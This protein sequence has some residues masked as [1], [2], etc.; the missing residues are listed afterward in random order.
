[1]HKTAQ[2]QRIFVAMSGG[3]DSSTAAALLV[4]EGHDV[5]GVFMKGWHPSFVDCTYKEDR[6][7]A[8]RVCAHLGIPF[9]ELDMEET[10]RREVI[11]ELLSEYAAGRTPNPDVLCNR[12]V[13]FGA[14]ATWARAN[15]A[16]AIATGHYAQVREH[17]GR[18]ALAVSADA[19]KD[20][21][22][23]LWTLQQDDLA[24][25]RFPIGGY[26]KSD[27][28]ALAAQHGLPTAEKKDSQ[29]VCFAGEL[30]MRDFLKRFVATTP[31]VVADPDGTP[32]GEHEGT[33]LYTIGQRRGFQTTATSAAQAP[34][35]IVAKDVANNTLIVSEDEADARFARPSITLERVSWVGAPPKDGTRLLGR[36]RY[37]QPLR[38]YHIAIAGASVAAIPEMPEPV[39]A[40]QSLVLYDGDVCVGGGIIT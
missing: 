33:A 20:Q 6:A 31:G 16:D 39:P 4:E 37:R 13:K 2:K 26:T 23:F 21:T 34:R 1:M 12:R 17:A 9:V 24:F 25:T 10:Y 38:P 40:G 29:G 30:S 11:D 28:R 5:T 36:F 7:D 3:V 14:F 35:Y 27:V 22:Y 19:A 18:Y 15:G 8:I 32:L